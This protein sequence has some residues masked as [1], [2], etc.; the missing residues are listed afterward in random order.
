[1]A[2]GDERITTPG[3]PLADAIGLGFQQVIES[4]R[5]D[6]RE[7]IRDLR[8]DLRTEISAS[9]GRVTARVEA[10]DLQGKETRAY[11]ETFARGHA[12]DHEAEAVERRVEHSK[13]YDFMRKA[14]L[15]E[16]RR[17]GALGVIRWSIEL[18]SKHSVQIV[19]ILGALGLLGG[20]A[21]GNI[22]LDLGGMPK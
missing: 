10:V 5:T 16:A 13:F 1:M 2:N 3:Q 20:F 14:E 8:V 11:I 9:E 22:H 4:L 18:L 19:T 6:V 15:N 12:E 21:T 17:D 7:D